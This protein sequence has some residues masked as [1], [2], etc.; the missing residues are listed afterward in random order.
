MNLRN[1]RIEITTQI[2]SLSA[3][4]TELTREL[5]RLEIEHT[6]PPTNTSF[7]VNDITTFSVNDEVEIFNNYKGQGGTRGR[8]IRIYP[9]RNRIELVSSSGIV[10]QR[11]PKNLIF[12]NN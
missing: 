4:I 2:T 12:A 9:G 6:P 7:S 10:Y 5:Q 3:R 11:A 8:V 1:R